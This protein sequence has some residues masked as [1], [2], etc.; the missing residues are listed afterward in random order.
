MELKDGKLQL[1]V[2]SNY[3]N[4]D[5]NISLVYVFELQQDRKWEQRECWKQTD[6]YKEKLSL[7]SC[8]ENVQVITK[9]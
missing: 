7:S 4:G 2:Y 6:I 3:P 5:R 9:L 8:S 1:S